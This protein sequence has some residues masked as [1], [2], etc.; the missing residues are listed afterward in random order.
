MVQVAEL[1]HTVLEDRAALTSRWL[2]VRFGNCGRELMPDRNAPWIGE[3]QQAPRLF[4]VVSWGAAATSWLASAL[5]DCPDVFCLH[6][7][8]RVW[9]RLS[10]ATVVDGLLYLQIVGRLGYTANAAGDVHGISQTHIQSI[11]QHYGDA[12]RCA[13]LVRDPF[14]RLL[15]QLAIFSQYSD[16]RLTYGDLSYLNDKFPEAVKQLP[17]GEH[18]ELLFLHAANMLN[19]IIDETSAGPIWRMEDLTANPTE[20]INAANYLTTHSV[21]PPADWAKKWA[22]YRKLNQHAEMTIDFSSW[23]RR[24]L[25]STVLPEAITAYRALGYDM[26]WIATL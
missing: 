16:P 22:G 21:A 24:A 17:G 19:S 15:S 7:A 2:A 13:V 20:L 3:L 4:S 14:C 1:R 26:G 5:N 11:K 25:R 10:G 8:N 18:E 9:S 23:Q 12:F 6:A